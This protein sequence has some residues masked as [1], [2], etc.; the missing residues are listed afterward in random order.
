MNRRK[1]IAGFG[2]LAAVVA[3][4]VGTNAF[5]SAE[6]NRTVNVEVA[7]DDKAFLAL[8]KAKGV[9]SDPGVNSDAYVNVNGGEV[10][11]DFSSNNG[12]ADLGNGFNKNAVVEIEDL[13]EVK[14]QGTQSVHLSIDLADLDISDSSG[15]NAYVGLAVVANETA[16]GVE[17]ENIAFDSDIP[18]SNVGGDVPDPMNGGPYELSTGESVHLDLTVD[19]RDFEDTGVSTSGTVTFIADQD[20]SL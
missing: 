19:T 12:T 1:F 13:L 18:G 14:N 8:Q 15:N 17:N 20:S 4:A 5:T 3:G 2:S 9:S 11:F 16:S 10:S 7:G 6:A